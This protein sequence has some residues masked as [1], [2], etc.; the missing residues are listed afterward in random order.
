MRQ[1]APGQSQSGLGD[2]L[3]YVFHCCVRAIVITPLA[4]QRESERGLGRSFPPWV[5]LGAASL[6]CAPSSSDFGAALDIPPARPPFLI[7]ARVP[8]KKRHE[9]FVTSVLESL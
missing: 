6:D 1:R 9:G 3:V 8:R 5:E 7:G 4:C 2:S